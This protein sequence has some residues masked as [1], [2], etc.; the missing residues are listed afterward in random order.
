MCF[1]RGERG[2]NGADGGSRQMSASDDGSRVD[3]S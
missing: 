3:M 2:N 1:A